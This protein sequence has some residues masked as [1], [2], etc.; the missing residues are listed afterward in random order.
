MEI[1]KD[2][3]SKL[4]TEDLINEIEK[5]AQ[6]ATRASSD[7]QY[8][9][10]PAYW[11]EISVLGQNELNLRLQKELSTE[12]G[13]LKTEI[14]ELKKNNK[15]S[16]R[17]TIFLS[18]ATILIACITLIIGYKTLNF[19]EADQESDQKWKEE[20]IFLLESQNQLLKDNNTKLDSLIILNNMKSKKSK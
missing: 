9:L 7:K 12:I 15:R 1:P 17:Q 2:Y 10:G 8:V 11:R 18:I 14:A 6:I 20:Q 13:N 3:P 5:Y 4:S 19:S 16:G